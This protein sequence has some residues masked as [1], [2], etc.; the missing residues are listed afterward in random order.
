LLA[1]AALAARTGA[2]AQV[3]GPDALAP[4][5]P[6]PSADEG[7]AAGPGSVDSD[8]AITHRPLRFPRDHGAHPGSRTEWWYLT[9]WLASAVEAAPQYGFQLTF[10]RVRTALGEALRSRFAPR[11]LLFAHA[12]L[13]DLGARRLRSD[14]RIARAGFG[15]AQAADNDTALRLRD[16][17]LQ[18]SGGVGPSVYRAHAGSERAGFALDLQLAATQPLLLQGEAGYS[19]KGPREEQASRYV[20]EP[21][22]AATGALHAA[23]APLAV[24]GRAWLDHEWSDTLM[25]PD[26]VGWD[27]V[28]FNFDDGSALMAFRLRRADG[29]TAW[30]ACT[31]RPSGGEA[32]SVQGV[33]AA[34]FTPLASWHSPATGARYPVRW[35]LA[36]PFGRW[37]VDALL[38]A[39][40]LDAASATGNVYWEGLSELRDAGGRRVALGYLEMTGYADVL[41]L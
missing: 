18:R 30:S 11:Q 1:L 7:A 27:W 5:V 15:I 32:R 22:L 14:A 41:R 13:T 24:H 4:A 35:Q 17:S 20:S 10:F 21:Q 31:W 25:P 36:T 34:H 23:G 9:G 28:G 37:Q 3:S 12:A 38:D 40:E 16:W 39:Q 8:S 2:R 29:S 33:D 26:A 6:P 19:R